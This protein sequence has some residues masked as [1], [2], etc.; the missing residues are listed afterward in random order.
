MA[1][2][3]IVPQGDNWS[4][5][6]SE[7]SRATAVYKTKREAISRGKVIARKNRSKLVIHDS[8]GRVIDKLDFAVD[9][10]LV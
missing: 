3:H 5:L 10:S 8:N 9:F 4:V 7:A 6:K 1:N 2:I